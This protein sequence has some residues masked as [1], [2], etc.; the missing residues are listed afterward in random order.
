MAHE[1]SSVGEALRRARVDQR[2]SLSDVADQ[3][4]ISIATLSRIETSKQNLDVP[5]LLILS[6]VL[7]VTASDLLGENGHGDG[8]ATLTRRLAKLR[9]AE[10]ARLIIAS[11]SAR[12]KDAQINVDD[13]LSTLDILRD[14]LLAVQRALKSRRGR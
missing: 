4:G 2:L 7:S 3:A 12:A 10:R 14:E 6:R 8:T 5:L 13:L 11:R 9:P 1:V